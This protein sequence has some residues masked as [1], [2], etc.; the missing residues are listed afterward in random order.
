M[1]RVVSITLKCLQ[2]LILLLVALQV[3][4]SLNTDESNLAFRQQFPDGV[5]PMIDLGLIALL[6]VK[7]IR[8][9]LNTKINPVDVALAVLFGA[10]IFP[11]IVSWLSFTLLGASYHLLLVCIGLTLVI[12]CKDVVRFM[13]I[14]SKI[15]LIAGLSIVLVAFVADQ[16]FIEVSFWKSLEDAESNA[17]LYIELVAWTY[18]VGGVSALIGVAN[19]VEQT[20][21]QPSQQK[22]VA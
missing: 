4:S 3:Y 14:S 19:F 8:K 12:F 15:P 17:T 16:F 11:D 9:G 5:R 1:V 10:L 7:S 22:T 13:H 6:I 20:W 21:L 18:L 2:I